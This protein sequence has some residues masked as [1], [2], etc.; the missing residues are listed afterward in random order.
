MGAKKTLRRSLV[1]RIRKYTRL[2]AIARMLHAWWVRI[3]RPDTVPKEM[4]GK[5][6]TWTPDGLK[7]VAAGDSPSSALAAAREAGVPDAL[8]E[9][10][11]PMEQ[12][13]GVPLPRQATGH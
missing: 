3:P 9:W 10:I 4:T 2:K 11:P 13:R 5:W 7:I 1:S 6:I 8:C 12:L